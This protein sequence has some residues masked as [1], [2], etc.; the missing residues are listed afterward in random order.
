M[1]LLVKNKIIPLA[2]MLFIEKQDYSKEQL[3][4]EANGPYTLEENQDCFVLRN[5]DCCKAIMVT[6]RATKE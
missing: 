6:V 2:R 1:E 4:I 3:I 5:A